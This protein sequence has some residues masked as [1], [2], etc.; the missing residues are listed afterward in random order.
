MAFQRVNGLVTDGIVGEKTWA[1]IC[2]GDG[3]LN[4]STNRRITELIVHCTATKEGQ[5]VT[6]EQVRNWHVKERGWSDIGYHFLIYLD[7]SVHAG[8]PLNKVGAHC[9]GHN[10]NSI[11][12]CYVGGLDSNGR[13]KDT[14][15]QAQK[16]TLFDL[17][18]KLRKM[19]PKA[20]IHGHYEFANKA[21][22]CFKPNEEY[23]GL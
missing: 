7:G 21:C 22:P 13:P 1:K 12:I 17:L 8:R 14:R 2:E 3:K 5:N 19:Y 16:A 18:R 20:T 23:K 15:T 6:V 10:T 11:G 4:L 9:T